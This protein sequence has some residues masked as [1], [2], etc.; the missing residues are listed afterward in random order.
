MQSGL[1]TGWW[2]YIK[3]DDK[4]DRPQLSG[5]LLRRVWQYARPYRWKI[6]GLLATIFVIT[7]LSLI[8]PLL[9]RDL[10]DNAITNRNPERINLL[11]IGMIGV[12]LL[13]AAI[14]FWQRYISATIGESLIADLRNGLYHHMSQMSLRFFTHSKTGELMSRLNTDVV[15]AQRAVTG[16][17]INIVT[18]FVSVAATL[19]I[20]FSLEWRLTLL[21]IAIVPF[22]VAPTRKVGQKLRL[23]RRQSMELNAKMNSLMQETLN[24]DGAL[25]V[26]LFGRQSKE[27][28][29]FRERSSDVAEIGVRSAMV[30]RWFFMG[31]GLISAVG[32]T[33]VFWLGGHMVLH[34]VFTVGTIVA[35]GAYLTQLYGPLSSIS[36]A[37]V[38]FA[39]SMVSFERVFEILDIPIE[40]KD[41]PGAITLS[42]VQGKVTFRDVS[43]SFTD[44]DNSY[45]GLV[46]LDTDRNEFIRNQPETPIM[47]KP[48]RKMA[49][50]NV[51]FT[52]EPGELAA[53]VGPSGA[54]KTTISYLLPRLY[55]PAEGAIL[56]DDKELH[57]ISQQS[58]AKAIGMVTQE[59]YLFNDTLKANL[60]YAKPDATDQE[61]KD[62]CQAANIHTFIKSL[63]DGYKTI[64]GARGYRLSGGE[65]QRIAIARVILKNPR[66]LVLDEATSSLDS[67]S[68]ALIQEA[69]QRIMKGRTSLVIAH[70]LSTILN[71]DLIL[72][73]DQGRIVEQAHRREAGSAH[74]QLL[75]NDGLY[76]TLYHTQFGD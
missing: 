36:N 31:L 28:Q 6:L 54:G 51:S 24:I 74:E 45:P 8:P 68:E 42:S 55:D 7:G 37:H 61:I 38:E 29:N 71:A 39:T 15:G 57:G 40:I 65:R 13:S 60:L 73:L 9:L 4:R 5:E 46:G 63:P 2:T 67:Q 75:S 16:T 21:S 17:F 20:M 22:F 56:L 76:A 35:F 49:L 62:A 14:G 18:N 66:I 33:L 1:G 72:V 11:A 25:L 43:F 23:I 30:G 52:I 26:K 48:S 41:T 10:I 19:I 27:S 64:V 44:N 47:V 3:Y 58:L 70:R 32:T 53:L 34:G 12:P 50:E 69:L 59:T